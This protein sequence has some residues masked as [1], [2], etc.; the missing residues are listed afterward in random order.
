MTLAT[1]QS[2][3]TYNGRAAI[4]E[5]LK[6]C[7]QVFPPSA[8][9]ARLALRPWLDNISNSKWTRIA[10]RFSRLTM[11]GFPFEWVFSSLDPSI[12]YTIEVSGPEQ[13]CADRLSAACSQLAQLGVSGLQSLQLRSMISLQ[14]RG[15]LRFGCWLGG[16]TSEDSDRY[17]LYIE[18]PEQIS[19]QDWLDL[20]SPGRQARFPTAWQLR[21]VGCELGGRGTE[22]YFAGPEIKSWEITQLP[23]YAGLQFVAGELVDLVRRAI[24]R[25]LPESFPAGTA[26]WSVAFD[27]GGDSSYSFF[28]F[29][30]HL[31]NDDNS[32]LDRLQRIAES[33][34][35]DL[36]LYYQIAA[37]LAERHCLSRH[38]GMVSFT[39]RNDGRLGMATGLRPPDPC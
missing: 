34:A 7:D 16:R 15:A 19:A 11:D 35:W 3:P 38:H 30:R 26:G 24:G 39:V 4:E 23:R 14:A 8:A 17:K 12:R 9:R 13:R 36:N 5:A 2:R 18:T 29:A 32:L 33:L 27:S 22:F 28:C 1:V 6:K 20:F 21:M 25:E 10:W 37:L 31:W